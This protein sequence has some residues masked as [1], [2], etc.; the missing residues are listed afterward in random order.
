[1]NLI[2]QKLLKGIKIAPQISNT[3]LQ[4]QKPVSIF[5]TRKTC[6]REWS[7]S[8]DKGRYELI[9]S[10]NK[11]I[12]ANVYVVSWTPGFLYTALL[13]NLIYFIPIMIYHPADPK[14]L[15]NTSVHSKV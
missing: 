8:W 15:Q 9:I 7:G 13:D 4:L 11:H 1:M 6:W 5:I 2:R 3:A 14:T 10:Y 12:G